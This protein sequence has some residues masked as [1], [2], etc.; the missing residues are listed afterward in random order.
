MEL[1]PEEIFPFDLFFASIV[2]MNLHPGVERDGA[3]RRTTEECALLA[4]EMIKVRRA[5]Y[6]TQVP[7]KEVAL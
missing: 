1:L 4:L 2:G 3:K 6:P 5:F 7:Q